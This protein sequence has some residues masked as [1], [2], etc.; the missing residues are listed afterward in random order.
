LD[1]ILI[2]VPL[3]VADCTGEWVNDDNVDSD[4]DECDDDKC[5]FI[6][7]DVV[8][9]DKEEPNIGDGNGDGEVEAEGGEG[10]ADGRV[11]I[12]AG[13]RVNECNDDDDPVRGRRDILVNF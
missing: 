12:N 8:N 11:F 10:D 3:L 5:A 4:N 9:D 2:M 1:K 13:D 6:N 7:A